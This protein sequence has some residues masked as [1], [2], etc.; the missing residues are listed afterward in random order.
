MQAFFP[1]VTELLV[2]FFVAKDVLFVANQLHIVG[3]LGGV[4]LSLLVS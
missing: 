4:V 2:I 3:F 1:V